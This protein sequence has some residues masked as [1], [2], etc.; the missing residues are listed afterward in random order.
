MA[1][2]V[3]NSK[4][5]DDINWFFIRLLKHFDSSDSGSIAPCYYGYSTYDEPFI[6]VLINHSIYWSYIQ[7]IN[8]NG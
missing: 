3:F 2:F 1:G 6:W 4:L 5:R 8:R 7:S